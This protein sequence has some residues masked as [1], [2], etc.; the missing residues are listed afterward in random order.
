MD[1]SNACYFIGKVSKNADKDFIITP[2]FGY[3]SFVRR[4]NL[5]GMYFNPFTKD[6][7]LHYE[8]DVSKLS[9]LSNTKKSIINKRQY[10]VVEKLEKFGKKEGSESY[11]PTLNFKKN[12]IFF[13]SLSCF[14]PNYVNI[15]MNDLSIKLESYHKVFRNSNEFPVCFKVKT[16][17]E[18]IEDIFKEL[19]KEGL[20]PKIKEKKIGPLDSWF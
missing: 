3:N 1:K 5:N 17:K 13:A 6:I 20:L 8:G 11:I 9:L 10:D 4:N 7:I 18:T 16:K 2:K 12:I 15:E 14:S 19:E